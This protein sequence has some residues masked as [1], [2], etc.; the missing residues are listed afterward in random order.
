MKIGRI[1]V[2]RVRIRRMM[3]GSLIVGCWTIKI[4]TMGTMTES[5]MIKVRKA[6][7][8]G[9]VRLNFG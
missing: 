6:M 8:H 2:E 9:Q 7:Y 3:M 1:I 5:M 4:T